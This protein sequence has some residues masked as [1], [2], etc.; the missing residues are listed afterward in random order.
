MPAVHISHLSFSFSA[1][2]PLLEDVDAHLGPGWTG[3]GGPNGAGKTTLLHLVTGDLEPDRGAI[4]IDPPGTRPVLCPQSVDE[5]GLDVAAMAARSDRSAHRTRSALRLDRRQ[6]D[7]WETLSPGERKR[8]QVGAALA[9]EPDV[10]IVDEPTN[11]LDAEARHLLLDA[12]RSFDGVGFVVSHDRAFLNELTRAILRFHQGTVVQWRGNYETAAAAWTAA[13]AAAASERET[14]KRERRKLRRRVADQRRAREA[15][16]ARARRER[17][18][19][20]VK[21]RDARSME[22]KG[23]AEAGERQAGRRL[24]VDRAR[25]ERVEDALADS[26]TKD[27]GRSLFFDYVPAPREWLI[28]LDVDAIRAGDAE[29]LTN[30]GVG[31]RRGDRIRLAGRN[32][33]GKSTLLTALVEAAAIPPERLVYLTQELTPAGERAALE[34]VRR[35]P[36]DER[37]RVLTLLAA[38][39]VDPAAL[40]ASDAPSP[41][42]ARKLEMAYGLGTR[43]W[44]LVLDEPTNHL[45]LPSITRLE[46][47]LVEYPG[48]LVIVTHDDALAA[49]TTHTTWLVADGTVTVA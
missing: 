28:S 38:L 48:A 31:V 5:P 34:A 1:A 4:T 16:S 42:E 6:L 17:R 29:L 25:L 37:G 15:T 33:A 32:G 30:V 8:W 3:V 46:A 18:T 2:V 21:D 35:L 47:A 7:R 12:L 44:L 23:R 40:L 14:L 19:A 26:L 13:E 22:K 10:L 9:A 20:G 39:G 24:E 41:G 36:A 45:D 11:H 49:A 43:A 27:K